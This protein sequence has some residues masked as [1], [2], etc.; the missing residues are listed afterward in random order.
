MKYTAA[1]NEEYKYEVWAMSGGRERG[2]VKHRALATASIATLEAAGYEILSKKEKRIGDFAEFNT[3][4]LVV[5]KGDSLL[6]LEWN[7]FNEGWMKRNTD[8]GG[9][10]IF[11]VGA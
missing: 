8:C 11:R 6:I 3:M 7:T 4:E 2:A 9:S 5:R 1:Q 10:T